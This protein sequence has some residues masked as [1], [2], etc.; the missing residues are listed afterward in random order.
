M[1]PNEKGTVCGGAYPDSPIGV[2]S[3]DDETSVEQSSLRLQPSFTHPFNGIRDFSCYLI[4]LK[5]PGAFHRAAKDGKAK[6]KEPYGTVTGKGR[7]YGWKTLRDDPATP[8]EILS[9]F[10]QDPDCN[11]GVIT[12]VESG[13]MVLDRDGPAP[14]CWPL[15]DLPPTVTVETGREGGRHYYYT[16]TEPTRTSS[17]IELCNG[18]KLQLKADGACVVAPGSLHENGKR[19]AFLERRGHGEVEVAPRF[20]D[21]LD[22]FH[23]SGSR[24]AK[25][26]AT[27]HK[28]KNTQNIPKGIDT[29]NTSITGTN[30]KDLKKKRG[31]ALVT[32]L[33]SSEV[34]TRKILAH[35]GVASESLGVAFL[36]PFPGKPDEKP[37]AVLLQG[38]GGQIWIRDYGGGRCGPWVTVPAVIRW[39][40]AGVA[41][42]GET[43]KER[44]A[45][46][47][48]STGAQQKVWHVRGAI[49]AGVIE[50]P[51]MHVKPVTEDVPNSIRKVYSGLVLRYQVNLLLDPGNLSFPFTWSFACGWC[52]IS[53][54]TTV[55]EAITWL[56]KHGYIHTC[57]KTKIRG[58]EVNLFA[59]GPSARQKK[60]KAVT[61]REL[62][63]TRAV[64]REE[65]PESLGAILTG[66]FEIEREK[67]MAGRGP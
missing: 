6:G 2:Y 45:Q 53:S 37:S 55:K 60:Q 25:N 33:V 26:T 7:G 65:A 41:L 16:C 9:W 29:N 22:V 62:T 61:K 49:E 5:P 66:S 46:L 40:A 44:T 27:P 39:K 10:A 19:Y 13:L 48:I 63:E 58:Q 36:S 12:G 31:D 57:D 21:L 24:P 4:P 38:E 14:G 35:Y 18:T 56:L 28:S 34:A 47:R 30:F 67:T 64:E 17:E 11:L 51:T 32:A 54:N 52:G 8:E 50:A 15:L 59:I 43:P 23:N 42:D 3:P 20:Q 1:I